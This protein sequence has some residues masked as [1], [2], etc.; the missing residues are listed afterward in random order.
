VAAIISELVENDIKHYSMRPQEAVDIPAG[1]SYDQ[2]QA[3]TDLHLDKAQME[4][5]AER[6]KTVATV[7]VRPKNL[8]C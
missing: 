8:K 5:L 2:L 7:E 3:R 4:S 6:A 1:L